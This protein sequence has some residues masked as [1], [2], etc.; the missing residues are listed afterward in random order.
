MEPYDSHNEGC[1]TKVARMQWQSATHLVHPCIR[2]FCIRLHMVDL[3]CTP[4]VDLIQR[5]RLEFRNQQSHLRS[6]GA[7]V[8]SPVR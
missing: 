4:F 3:F 1:P 2:E 8:V 5:M 7:E 6:A